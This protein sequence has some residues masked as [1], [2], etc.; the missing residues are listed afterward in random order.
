MNKQ[1]ADIQA[2]IDEY[3][4]YLEGSEEGDF[5]V[6]TQQKPIEET[7]PS[8]ITK[9]AVPAHGKITK[10]N[11]KEFSGE[12]ILVAEDNLINQ[13]VLTSLFTETG[14][15]VI[16]ANDG[17]EALDILEKDKNFLLILMDAHMPRVDGFEATR[18]IRKNRDYNHILVVALSGDTSVDDI[19]KMKEA[20]MQ[21][22]LEKPLKVD[23]LYDIFYAYSKKTKIETKT[24]D[25]DKGLD[26]C[27]GDNS[28]YKEILKEFSTT[29]KDSTQKLNTM[30]LEENLREADRFML[31]LIGITANIGADSLNEIAK[32]IKLSLSN[33]QE[34]NY[35]TLIHQYESHLKSLIL[36]I[37]NYK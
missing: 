23:K 16:I 17:Q 7:P 33:T 32:E 36:I 10:N 31:D 25:F 22:Q 14:I 13:K 9:K 18:I 8:I 20:G 15:E 6:E 26:V 34:K 11:F 19:R 29:Y 4:E 1:R 30:F 21:E 5:G 12:R 35:L 28:F 2:T 3:D 27:G 37:E 24:L